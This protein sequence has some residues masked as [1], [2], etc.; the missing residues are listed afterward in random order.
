MKYLFLKINS[1]KSHD[2]MSVTLRDKCPFYS[3]V[4]NW[5]AGFKTG[6]LSAEEEERSG[7]PTQVRVP[8]NVPLLCQLRR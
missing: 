4:R 7:G 6:H 2:D 5:V 8:G 1:A 3:T